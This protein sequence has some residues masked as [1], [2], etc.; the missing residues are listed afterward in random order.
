L[1]LVEEVLDIKDLETLSELNL[2]LGIMVILLISMEITLV[3]I[4]METF[5]Q[6]VLM[7][8]QSDGTMED[9]TTPG[10]IMMDQAIY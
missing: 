6:S 10:S 4:L 5:S 1:E 3:L 9:F 8:T 7:L 2:I